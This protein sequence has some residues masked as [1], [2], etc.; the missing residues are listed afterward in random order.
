M[1]NLKFRRIIA[2]ALAFALIFT[3]SA[4][5][6]ASGG[7][8]FNRAGM[9]DV[10]VALERLYD[11]PMQEKELLQN[12]IYEPE[13]INLSELSRVDQ[14]LVR[15]VTK[16]PESYLVV[17]EVVLDQVVL[18]YETSDPNVMIAVTDD[19]VDVI[20]QIAEYTFLINGEKFV[21]EVTIEGEHSPAHVFGCCCSVHPWDPPMQW[22]HSTNPPRNVAYSWTFVRTQTRT[23]SSSTVF[24]DMA[25]ATLASIAARLLWG[26]QFLASAATSI[27]AVLIQSAFRTTEARLVTRYYNHRTSNFHRRE[28]IRSYPVVSGSPVFAG[29]TWHYFT[30][31]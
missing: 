17:A 31:D 11:L 22:W 8:D 2:I 16:N 23:L 15:E 10:N 5:L 26:G 13:F 21:F 20:E 12:A 18:I 7:N 25:T 28:V 3:T 1:T 24:A 30:L 27:A 4:P 19:H 14:A 9:S 6:F 29:T